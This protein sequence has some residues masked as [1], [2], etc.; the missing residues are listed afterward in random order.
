VLLT[1]QS[2][3]AGSGRKWSKNTQKKPFPRVAAR[4]FMVARSA[5]LKKG[6]THPNHGRC[7][8]LIRNAWANQYENKHA[9]TASGSAQITTAALPFPLPPALPL[10]PVPLAAGVKATSSDKAIKAQQSKPRHQAQPP[11]PKRCNPSPARVEGRP[12][13]AA[14]QA[15]K[16]DQVAAAG[17]MN[18]SSGTA[19]RQVTLISMTCRQTRTTPMP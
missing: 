8:L 1:L 11:K 7:L 14:I 12:D 9:E 15:Q 17:A 6:R 4:C 3:M 5:I 19:R 13:D 10:P 18:P 16:V 2:A